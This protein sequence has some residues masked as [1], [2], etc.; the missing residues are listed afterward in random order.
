MTGVE[1]VTWSV[2]GLVGVLG[3]SACSGTEI[4]LYSANRARLSLRV[5]TGRATRSERRLSEE[6]DRPYRSLAT[7]LIANTIFNNL[8]AV[9]LT[10]LLAGAG[11]GDIAI[12]VLTAG[13]LTP[14]LFVFAET[15]PKELFR[16]GS[17]ALTARMA[18]P[19]RAARLL[20][21]VIP[22]V[23]LIQWL[24]GLI[25]RFFGDEGATVWREPRLRIAVLLKEGAGHGV[26]SEEQASLLDRALAV[27]ET[28]V[29]AE[30]TGWPSVVRATARDDG[31]RR[32]A[33][34]RSG[35]SR[36]PVLDRRGAVIGVV[37]QSALALDPGEPAVSLMG[38][39]VTVD[40]ASNVLDALSAMSRA[41]ARLAVVGTADRPLG[42]VTAKDLIEPLTGELESW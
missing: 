17:D 11:F 36:F 5:G 34:V 32:M 28:S 40:P 18:L 10:A 16:S 22:V 33:L 19:L 35:H 31:R 26:I 27:H 42:V 7:L 13:V 3:S 29:R 25:T 38:P 37:E 9:G 8:G 41:G 23:P 1:A 30:M 6:L 21:T 12:I 20:L 2:V 14:V 24:T 39:V 15:V 4:G